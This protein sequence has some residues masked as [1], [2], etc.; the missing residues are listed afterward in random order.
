MSI[1][2][3]NLT[4]AH[5][6]E[7]ILKKGEELRQNLLPAKSQAAYEKVYA[8]FQRWKT[9]ESIKLVNEDVILAYLDMRVCLM[10]L[11]NLFE[12]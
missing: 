10:A 2:R 11:Q 4:M 6:P 1:I 7:H 8:N 3:I 12:N 5:I 9:D